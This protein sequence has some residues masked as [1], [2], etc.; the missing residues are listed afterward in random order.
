MREFC[1]TWNISQIK[2][3]FT[4]ERSALGG[5]KST[6][7]LPQRRRKVWKSGGCLTIDYATDV[8]YINV[9]LA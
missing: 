5:F 7:D 2:P 8:Q 6:I 9:P 3:D 4:N 1:V